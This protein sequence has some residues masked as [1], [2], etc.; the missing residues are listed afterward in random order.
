M[1]LISTE[2]DVV[3][4][5]EN[6]K[7][8][9]NLG[10]YIPRRIDSKNNISIRMGTRIRVKVEDLPNNSHSIVSVR[11]DNLDCNEIIDITWRD[12]ND[13]IIN[14]Y[15]CYCKKCK[16]DKT[17]SF[18]QYLIDIY[19]DN[20]LNLY[21][22]YAK[23][24]IDPWTISKGS[25][26]KVFIKC[27]NKSYHESYNI[28]CCNFING[29][30]CPSCSSKHG[31]LHRLDSMAYKHPEVLY[32][33]QVKTKN[34]HMKFLHIVIKNFFGVVQTKNMRIFIDVLHIQ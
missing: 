32:F 26:K 25:N 5:G 23:N 1:E 18:A 2:T 30:R 20:A 22:D 13:R 3:L 33:G 29:K 6:I 10:Y 11:C 21:W 24:I 19:G 8:Y 34:R 31:K 12:Y 4:S 17:K 9:E 16:I 15:N 28:A 7:Y 27:Q 14:N